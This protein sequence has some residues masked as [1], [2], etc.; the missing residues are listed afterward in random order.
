VGW[1]ANLLAGPYAG[2]DRK[3]S[4]HPLRGAGQVRGGLVRFAIPKKT[5]SV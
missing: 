5:Q 1:S 4:L 3:S 2:R